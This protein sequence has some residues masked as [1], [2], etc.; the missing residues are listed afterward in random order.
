MARNQQAA[1]PGPDEVINGRAAGGVE[2][3]GRLIEQ[4]EVHL[5]QKQAGHGKARAF[6]AAERCDPAACVET[7]KAHLREGLLKAGLQRPVGMIKIFRRAVSGRNAG[8]AR[9]LACDANGFG[10]SQAFIEAL[11]QASGAGVEMNGP[12]Q[13]SGV[14]LDR[15]EQGGFARAIAADKADAFAANRDGQI[16]EKRFAVRRGE[17]EI[18]EGETGGHGKESGKNGWAAR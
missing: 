3:V 18:V 17:G 8:E 6:A 7:R 9:K 16:V 2:I 14:L 12:A 15:S 5:I 1:G 11:A 10:D 4:E 13:G